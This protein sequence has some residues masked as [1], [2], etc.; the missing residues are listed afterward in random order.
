VKSGIIILIKSFLLE[1]EKV[2]LSLPIEGLT[3]PPQP[4]S[5]AFFLKQ[6]NPVHAE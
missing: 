5:I 4:K 3:R 1:T 2:Y 6:L